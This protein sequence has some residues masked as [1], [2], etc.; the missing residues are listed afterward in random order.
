MATRSSTPTPSE[1]TRRALLAGLA[2]VALVGLP[3]PALALTQA[4]ARTL[5]D[6]VISEIMAVINSRQSEAAMLGS[7]EGI[8]ARYG[9]VPVI[10]RSALGPAARQASP[11]QLQAYTEAFRGYM[12]RK[13]GR[14]FREFIGG[15]I[16][17]RDARPLR[18][19]F[20]VVSIAYLR[21][22]P[23]FEVRWHIS[24]RSGRGLFFN[25]IIEGVNMLSAERTEI[26]AMLQRRRGDIAALTADLQRAG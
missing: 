17:V 4:E 13:Y 24:D 3:R 23:P 20:E 15:R 7:F 18:D 16:E 10:A 1:L 22:E 9:D 25:M 19:Y 2:A 8:F 21:G 14:R 5:V 26:Q 6:R 11:A 12:A